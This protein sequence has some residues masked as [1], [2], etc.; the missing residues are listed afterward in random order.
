M[1]EKKTHINLRIPLFC[2]LGLS[3]GIFLYGRA[4]FGGLVP[5][6]FVFLL[7]FC[8]FALPPFSLRRTLALLCAVCCFAGIGALSLHVGTEKFLS[9]LPEGEYRISGTV[10]QI[11]RQRGYSVV[12]L[13]NLSA[14]G[15]EIGG[16]CRASVSDPS[17]RPADVLLFRAVLHPVGTDAMSFDG[18]TQ[19]LFSKDVR[20][21]ATAAETE[22]IARSKNAFLRLNCALFNVLHDNMNTNEADVAYALLTGSSGSMDED[23]SE[24][25]RR[26][27]VAHIFAVSGLHI[28]ILYGAVYLACP[29]LKRLRFLPPLV[30]AVLYAG[31]CGFSVSSLRAVIMCGVLGTVR[32]L[33]KKHDF[34]DSVSFAALAVLLLFPREWFS[35]GMRLSFGACLGLALFSGDLS[36]LFAR[37]KFPRFLRGYLSANLSVQFFTFPILL[38]AF[39]YLSVWGVLCNLI[40]IP[41]L[42]LFFLTV[43]L[44]TLLALVIPPAAPFFLIFPGGLLSAFL[45]FFSVADVSLV[46]TGFAL[47]AGGTVFLVLCVVLSSRFRLKRKAVA[48]AVLAALFVLTAVLENVV[49]FGT[50]IDVFSRN[51]RTAALVRT[52]TESVLILDGDISLS[53]CEDFLRR[54]FGGT[55]SAAVALSEDELDALNVAAFLPAEQVR[56]RD[57][58]ETG[59]AREVLFGETFRIGSLSFRYESRS[60]LLLFAEGKAV[61]F[62]FEEE[63]ALGADLF[64]GGQ[65]GKF[66]YYL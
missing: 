13:E 6:D 44:F 29:F 30:L 11:S 32:A 31:L 24:A 2:A 34:L 42:P 43:L 25:V 12:I 63:P 9:A 15:K 20:Y 33:G 8:A 23:L 22:L 4:R 47:G 52:R 1:E 46:V 59:L 3:F 58:T 16:K 62:C 49:F 26:G 27:G 38:E 28:G 56:H 64:I 21:T 35:A 54:N 17:V 14:D 66:R 5:S 61:E 45:Y 41:V 50:R 18:Y 53:D 60:R 39:G 7:L 65:S 55:L 10:T 57:E 19:D 51:G 37:L 48:A 36:R 40:L